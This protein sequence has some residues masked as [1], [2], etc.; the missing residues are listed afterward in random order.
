MEL[1]LRLDRIKSDADSTLGL[2]F[3]DGK[4]FG[5]VVEDEKREVKVKGE[6]R[7]PA[8]TYVIKQRKVD[9]P[10]TLKYRKK[11]DFFDY[12]FELQEVPGFKHVYIHIGNTDDDS[13]G[14]LLVNYKADMQGLTGERSTQC[15]EDLYKMM[16]QAD[17]IEITI[18]DLD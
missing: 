10:M 17:S 5:F 14:C 8:G 3:A 11:F 4:P 16:K 18:R 9:S 7:I 13:E 6:T 1:N 12:H 15:F 2:L